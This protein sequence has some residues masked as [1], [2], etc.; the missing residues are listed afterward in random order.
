MKTSANGW[1]ASKDKK[2]ID[3]KNYM[4][5]GTTRH[6]AL[7]TDCAPIMC[8]FF[9]EFHKLVEP[10][11]IG[12]FDDWGYAFRDV[13]GRKDLSSHASGTAGDVN[14]TKHGLGLKHTFSK[15]KVAKIQVLIA[16]YGIGW[17]GNYKFRKDDM[18][19]EMIESPQKAK[20]RIIAMGLKQPKEKK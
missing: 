13:R 10:I 12:E 20:A 3:V 18:H 17:G 14:S 1:P 2:E 6:F 9:A 7:A 4:V 15:D 19:F 5:A 8:A 16:K 11:D